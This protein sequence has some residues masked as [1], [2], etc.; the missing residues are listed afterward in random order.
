M[1]GFMMNSD[2]IPKNA[3]VLNANEPYNRM[4]TQTN[5]LLYP[6]RG[7]SEILIPFA[8]YEVFMEISQIY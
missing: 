4:A 7:I 3:I 2:E 5:V 8:I 6:M 1:E